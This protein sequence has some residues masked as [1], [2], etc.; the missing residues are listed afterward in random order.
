MCA[1]TRYVKPLHLPTKPVLRCEPST[2]SSYI[3][4]LSWY[5]DVN[6]V[7]RALTS[8]HIS[9]T[10]MWT[11]YPEL[12]HLPTYPTLRCEPSTQSSYI[13]PLSWYW[14]VNPVPRAL[15]STHISDTEIWT[16]YP[17]LLHLPTY[18]TLRCEPSTQSSYIYP[19]IRHWDVNPVPRSFTSTHWA[20][21]EIWTQYPELLHLPTYPTLRCEPSTQSSYIYPHI[22]HWDVNPVSRAFTSTHWAGTEMW[23]QYPEPLHLPIKPVP[24]CEPS[25]H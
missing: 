7:P 11:Q 4:P 9:D 14:D 23:T 2:Q 17:E 18:P 8:T 16:Q 21:T 6:P 24:R 3:Y 19:H 1:F 13:Y 22:R 15:T 20:G 25:I 5:W 10:E 12:L